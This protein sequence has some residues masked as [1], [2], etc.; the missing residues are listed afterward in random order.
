[1]V[2]LMTVTLKMVFDTVTKVHIFILNLALKKV[3]KINMREDGLI[4]LKMEL[5]HK[6]ILDPEDTKDIGK[7]EK[8]TVK[9]FSF[10]TTKIYIQ[11]NGKMEKKTVK[12]HIF[13]KKQ[14]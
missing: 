7:M 2:I 6:L 8:G 11:D 3:K 13:L 10:M 5:D 4:I 9:E 12:E 1:M 14:E